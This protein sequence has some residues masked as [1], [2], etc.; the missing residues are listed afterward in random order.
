MHPDHGEIEKKFR[1]KI[2]VADRIEAVLTELRE[3]ELACDRFAVENDGR[4]DD[5][6]GAE[7]QH[8]GPPRAIDDPSMITIERFDVGEEIMA[9]NDRLGALKMG[10][11]R[12]DRGLVPLRQIQQRALKGA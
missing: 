12:H 1:D 8:A 9:E 7:R 4:P 2:A 6:P 10:V 11:A 3:A 5:R